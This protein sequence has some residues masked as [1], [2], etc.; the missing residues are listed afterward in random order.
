MAHRSQASNTLDKGN[1]LSQCLYVLLI[2]KCLGNK[3]SENMPGAAVSYLWPRKYARLNL[4][5][6]HAG[7]TRYSY[8]LTGPIVLVFYIHSNQ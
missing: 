5:L 6:N 4:H 1:E 7:S 8:Y 3:L 2:I